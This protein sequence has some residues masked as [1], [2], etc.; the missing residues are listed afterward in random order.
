[1]ASAPATTHGDHHPPPAVAPATPVAQR[2]RRSRRLLLTTKTERERHRRA[3]D[4]RVRA[5]RRRPGAA[6]RRC[7]RT[8]RTGCPG[9][10]ARVRRE[11]RIASPA[12][13]R[14]PRTRV[15]S[16]ASMATSVPVPIAS[17]R[18]A[19][20][21]A[22]ASLTPSPTMATTRPVPLQPRDHG[23]LVGGQHVGDHLVDADLGG[24][25]PRRPR[26]LS[27]VSSTGVSPRSRSAAHRRRGGRLRPCRPRDQHAA[28]A[29]VPAD[30][31]RGAP[32]AP[33]SS[34]A[35]AE[36]GGHAD[37]ALGE[38]RGPARRARPGGPRPGPGPR[39]PSRLAKSVDRAAARARRGS[40]PTTAR[41]TGCSECGLD[42]AAA[43][44]RTA[45]AD[46]P[47]GRDHGRPAPSGRW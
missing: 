3:G 9:S 41:A 39:S 19:W 1:M 20:A 33:A 8:P 42:G 15:R 11:S 21:S 29:A 7:R 16:L 28:G 45:S 25:G 38:Q 23:D 2:N 36:L 10:C 40:V 47:C 30:A 5:G 22:A 27:P 17:P 32:A 4:H 12:S 31:H 26:S 14:S 13:R 34:T 6:R 44:R 43:V 35:A 24:H 37:A 46:S 18:S